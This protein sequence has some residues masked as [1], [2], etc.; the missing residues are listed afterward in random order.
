MGSTVY[1]GRRVTAPESD[2]GS[3][4]AGYLR[5]CVFDA[6]S[7][8]L[9]IYRAGIWCGR[10]GGSSP[11]CRVAAYLGDSNKEPSS[12]LG[13]FAS[14]VASTAML[15]ITGG[16]SYERDLEYEDATGG[17]KAILVTAGQRVAGA[18]LATG[19]GLNHS[20]K[21][22]AGIT[23]ENE[24]FY[25]RTGLSQPP[26]ASF[27]PFTDLGVQGHMTI[28]FVAETNDAPETPTNLSPA[29]TIATLTPLLAADFRDKNAG[30]GGT[31]R[32][33]G[34]TRYQLEV[35]RQSDGVYVWQPAAF[36]ANSAEKTNKRFARDYGGTALVT[37]VTYEWRCRVRDR[38]GAWSPWTAW[39]AFTPGSLGTVT[40]AGTP[41]G[42]QE[43]RQPGPFQFSWSHPQG[44][45]TNAVEI[46]LKQGSTIVRTSPTIAKSVASGSSGSITWAETTWAD[47][48]WGGSYTYEVR[49]RDT[50]NAWSNWSA[51]RSFTVNAVPGIPTNLA[52]AQSQVV[53]TLPKLACQASDADDDPG[54]GLVVKARIKDSN[55]NVLQTRT[56]TYNA[57]TGQ[58]EYQTT[59]VDLASY[60]TYRWD[61]Y[62]Y[63]GTVYSG[64]ATAE[65]S[66]TASPEATFAYAQGPGVTVTSP[67]NNGTVTTATPT[68]QWS[69]TGGT[70]AQ[71][72]VRVWSA[73]GYDAG[74][75]PLYDSGWVTDGSASFTQ[76]SGY[77]VNGQ[78]YDLVVSVKDT[79]NLDGQ[80]T[81]VRFTLQYT[82]PATL[83]GVVATPVQLGT[84]PWP[85]AIRISWDPTTE[86]ESSW[87]GYVVYRDDLDRPLAEIA[88]PSETAYLDPLPVSGRT[89]RYRVTQL[90]S[91]EGNVIESAAAEVEAAVSLGGV[92]LASVR[93]PLVLRAI[94]ARV[95]ERRHEAR[96][97]ETTYQRW[98]D[99]APVT[100]RTPARYWQTVGSYQLRDDA[101]ATAAQRRQELEALWA[102]GGTLCYRDERGVKRFVTIPADGLVLTDL[103]LGRT[104]VELTLREEQYREGVS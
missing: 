71:K 76:P 92:V 50:N 49:A 2:L 79:L 28:W 7:Q 36:D 40:L 42:K 3:I 10:S 44:L 101:V 22:A 52:P 104:D 48:D 23:A 18:V 27:P 85:T 58:W 80:S 13:Y 78:S 14:F 47:L 5:G 74:A 31:D 55:G 53:T 41:T 64:G 66:A 100:V 90:A 77:L 89:Y 21:A 46:R 72:R 30:D 84:D 37:G 24:H 63:D 4:G 17:S 20:M 45:A 19:A 96:G 12:R 97:Q 73:G 94:L 34:L 82:P 60:A 26:P 38:A 83:T 81:P 68:Y 1:V 43:T 32:G 99:A 33:D 57:S 54:T 11:T 103:R 39:T 70:Q 35:R 93:D 9:W 29:G 25:Q 86:P 56:M 16:A 91:R 59:S 15:D 62:S 67:A 6:V 87:L 51:G 95:A 98:G 75:P 65:A 69:V 61:A 88:D 102:A 8:A